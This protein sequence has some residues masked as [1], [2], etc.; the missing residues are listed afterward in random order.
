MA[1]G[2]AAGETAAGAAQ[3]E[4][5]G[6]AAVAAVLLHTKGLEPESTIKTLKD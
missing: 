1:E 2:G 5:P 3:G 6:G 4:A